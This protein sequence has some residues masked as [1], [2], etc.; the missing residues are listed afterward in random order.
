MIQ[1][2]NAVAATMVRTMHAW[3]NMSTQNPGNQP[4]NAPAIINNP[5]PSPKPSSEPPAVEGGQHGTANDPSKTRE[6][7]SK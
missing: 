4:V 5:S 1:K 2:S 3:L 6:G 7:D